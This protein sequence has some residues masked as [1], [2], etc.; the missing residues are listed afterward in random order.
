MMDNNTSERRMKPIALGR[1]NYLFV[2]SERGGKS[3]A[4]YDSSVETCKNNNIN[5]LEYLTDI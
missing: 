2:G 1:K 3:A 4:T 5:P